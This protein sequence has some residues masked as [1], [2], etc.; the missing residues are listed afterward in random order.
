MMTPD[1]YRRQAALLR[2]STDPAVRKLGDI[3]DA[4]AREA[5]RRTR[6]RPALSAVPDPVL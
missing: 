4:L 2:K 3:G 5:E 6:D 1:Q